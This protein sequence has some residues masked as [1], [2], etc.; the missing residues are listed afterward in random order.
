[1]KEYKSQKNKMPKILIY[2]T[3]AGLDKDEIDFWKRVRAELNRNNIDIFMIGN[4]PPEGLSGFPYHCIPYGLDAFGR[5][6]YSEYKN[7][8][9]DTEL[10]VDKDELL[11]QEI[12]WSGR[13]VSEKHTEERKKAINMYIDYFSVLV[14]SI[15]PILTVVWNGHHTQEL[16]LREICEK[17]DSPLA[18]IERGPFA[19]NAFSGQ[20]RNSRR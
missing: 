7:K 2:L 6:E 18:F 20:R 14:Y 9:Y 1:M 8:L 11:A 15:K 3:S 5:L 12:F 4:L 13:A 16:I 19:K 17:C 10:G